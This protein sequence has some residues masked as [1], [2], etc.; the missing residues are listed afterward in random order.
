MSL[1]DVRDCCRC[2]TRRVHWCQPWVLGNNESRVRKIGVVCR[3][4]REGKISVVATP[5]EVLIMDAFSERNLW[6]GLMVLY[7]GPPSI[8]GS[9]LCGKPWVYSSGVLTAAILL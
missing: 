5:Y 6:A 1:L 3:W 8:R 4:H 9:L 2:H 7:V